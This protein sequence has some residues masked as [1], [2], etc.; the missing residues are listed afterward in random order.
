ML[1]I[2]WIFF[3]ISAFITALFKLVFLGDLLIFNQIMDALF[4]LS[5]TAFE[6]SLGLTG[7]LALW[8]GIMRIAETSGFILII[9]R[10]LSPNASKLRLT[11]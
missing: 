4:A 11:H 2:L 6:I 3:F 7:V 5:K 8:L 1:N 10:W 9:T